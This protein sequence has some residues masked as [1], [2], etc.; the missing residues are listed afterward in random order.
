PSATNLMGGNYTVTVTLNG[1][2]TTATTSVTVNDLPNVSAG[3]NQTLTCASPTV[4]LS[5]S[6]ISSPVSYTWTGPGLVSGANVA[7]ATANASGTYTLTVTNTLTGCADT[8]TVNVSAN[9]VVP[10]ISMGSSQTITCTNSVVTVS[11]SSSTSGVTYQWSSGV[12]NATSA[13]TTV[14][15]PGTYILTVTDPGNGC[16]ISGTIVVASLTALP[17]VSAGSNQDITCSSPIVT[18][19]GSST[20][21]GVNYQW[22]PGGSA[23]NS[24]STMVNTAGIYTLTVTDPTNGCAN[25]ATVSV[26]NNTTLPN[27]SFSPTHTLTCNVTTVTLSASSTSTGATYFWSPGGSN[28]NGSSTSVSTSDNYTLTVTDPNNGCT[29]SGTVTVSSNVTPPTASASNNGSLCPGASISL[30]GNGGV[31]YSWVGPNGFISNQ[32]NPILTNSSSSMSGSYILTVT[33]SN[34][35]S[36]TDTTFVIVNSSLNISATLTQPSCGASNGSITATINGGQTPYNVQWS[37]GDFGLTADSLASEQYVVQVTDASGCYSSLTTNLNPSN[38][39]SVTSTSQN[40]VTCNGGNNGSLALNI[41]GGSLPINILWSNGATSP[42]VSNLKAGVYDVVLT[43]ASGCV[44]NASYNVTEP[45]PIAVSFSTTPASCGNN[46]GSLSATVTGGT[47]PYNLQWSA[48]AGSQTTPTASN[49]GNGIYSLTITDNANCTYSASGLVITSSSGP[50]L[51]FSVTPSVGCAGSAQGSIDL[52]PSGGVSPYNFQ[53]SNGSTNE[54]ISNL[55]PGTYSVVVS[56]GDGCSSADTVVVV[57]ASGNTNPEICIVTVDSFTNTNKVIWEKPGSANG[58]KEYKIYRE[59]SALNVYNQI[60]TLPF[61]S[62]SEYTDPVANPAVRAWR[63]KIT[64]K[65]SCGVETVLSVNH[66]TIHLAV[67]VGISNTRN[68]AWDDYEGFPFLTFNIWRYHASTGWVKLDSLPSNLH[69]YTDL[70]P[71]GGGTLDYAIEVV[72]PNSC[73]STRG[74]INTTRSNIRN[75]VAPLS[76]NIDDLSLTSVK[77]FPNPAQNTFSIGIT[78]KENSKMNVTL[79]DV[80]GREVMLTQRVLTSGKNTETFNIS[81]LESGVYFISVQIGEKI[82]RTK[83]VKEN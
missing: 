28:P 66:K 72:R 46:D 32:Q 55:S 71:P 73:N 65:D 80:R 1:C 16:T 63:Y 47:S 41:N 45:D 5:G 44:V 67:N 33:G 17:N 70:N 27:F 19:I 75:I 36:S 18:L 3:P 43:D 15:T 49:L 48:N 14:N 23:P 83:L 40:N 74:I 62:L 79:F 25:T 69:S 20:T 21:S 61:D 51:S 53:W 11:G 38:G 39:P 34:G 58:I 82:F 81:E 6:S 68:L 59:G 56:G 54:D 13:T 12:A 37:N 64:Y 35:C 22:S 76:T 4:T 52:T 60:K 42:T 10:N 57:N 50:A 78:S 29:N 30:L 2:T 8:S 9:V 24:A 77:I 26:S 31:N 7:T